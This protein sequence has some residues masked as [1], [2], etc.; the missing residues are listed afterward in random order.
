MEQVGLKEPLSNLYE[1]FVFIFFSCMV[2]LDVLLLSSWKCHLLL[3][4][5]L[6]L[7]Q[8]SLHS[9]PRLAQNYVLLWF[10]KK[11]KTKQNDK[12]HHIV[13]LIL[14]FKR[15]PFIIQRQG[16]VLESRFLRLR[17]ILSIFIE[18]EMLHGVKCCIQKYLNLHDV[19]WSWRSFPT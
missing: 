7:W 11:N 3:P 12:K 14:R 4:T 9:D 13:K 17:I 18:T 10:Q 16:K 2:V 1:I 19:T 6:I 15:L 5:T 8:Q